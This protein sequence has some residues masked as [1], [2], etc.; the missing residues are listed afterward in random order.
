MFFEIEALDETGMG[1]DY[2]ARLEFEL[3]AHMVSPL[4]CLTKPTC[5]CGQALHG[6]FVTL[7]GAQDCRKLPCAMHWRAWDPLSIQEEVLL[8]G[9]EIPPH[10]PGIHGTGL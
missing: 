4:Y 10:H 8:P 3:F 1:E 2:E 7:A 6:Y 5:E 9:Y